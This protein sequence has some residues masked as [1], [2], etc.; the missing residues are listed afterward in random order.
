[1]AAWT[2]WRAKEVTEQ[3]VLAVRRAAANLIARIEVANKRR[4]SLGFKKRL[5]L[6]AEEGGRCP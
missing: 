6:F 4:H 2:A 1:M 5:D 3:R